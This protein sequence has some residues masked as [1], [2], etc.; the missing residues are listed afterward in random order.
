MGQHFQGVIWRGD[1]EI[2]HS[3]GYFYG[4]IQINCVPKFDTKCHK[5]HPIS[6]PCQDNLDFE[7][8]LFYYKSDMTGE[9]PLHVKRA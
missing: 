4:I 6:Y 5:K 2:Y 8:L 7:I 1:F 9:R 3:V